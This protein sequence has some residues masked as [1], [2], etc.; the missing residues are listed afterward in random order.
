LDD[1]LEKS[2]GIPE[3]IK[4][5]EN[6]V[7]EMGRDAFI[8]KSILSLLSVISK[9][10]AQDTRKQSKY[11]ANVGVKVLFTFGL[12]I[13]ISV[14]RSPLFI[15]AILVYLLLK[16]SFMEAKQ[17]I[18]ILK[19]S[20]IMTVFTF[21]VLLPA[22]IWGNSYSLVMLPAKV[23]ATITAV[24]ILSKT[25]NW[26]NITKALKSVFMPDIFIL[27][28]DITIKYILLLGELALQLLYALKLRSVGVNRSKQ[29]SLAG[30]SGTV[31]MRS[32]EMAEEMYDAMKCRGFTGEYAAIERSRWTAADALYTIVN[33]S[34]IALFI[35]TAFNEML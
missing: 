14:S 6:Q 9:I 19:I 27:V 34:I 11:E 8:N 29:T 13:M 4:K 3:W 10:K 5:E 1:R 30:I 20:L 17:I 16:L 24:N 35:Y 12:V 31:F 7:H 25:S 15:A 32:E 2:V 28:L 18:R 33:C 21:I 26:S 23:F 22:A